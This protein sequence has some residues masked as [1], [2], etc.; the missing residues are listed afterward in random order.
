MRYFCFMFFLM[1]MRL[2]QKALSALASSGRVKPS[3][4]GLLRSCRFAGK[5]AGTFNGSLTTSC[6][7]SGLKRSHFRAAKIPPVKRAERVWQGQHFPCA[8]AVAA[9]LRSATEF[10][11]RENFHQPCKVCERHHPGFESKNVLDRNL[12]LKYCQTMKR[13]RL[14][15]AQHI[16]C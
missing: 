4:A 14:Q 10:S 6:R 12:Q 2:K 5:S 13:D 1:V 9:T 7:S 15:I 11:Q 16:Y 8:R 3:Y